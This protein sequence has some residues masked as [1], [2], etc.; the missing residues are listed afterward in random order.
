MHCIECNLTSS[1]YI[2]QFIHFYYIV[3]YILCI[4]YSQYHA[5]P[6]ATYQM[7][8]EATPVPLLGGQSLTPVTQGTG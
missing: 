7:D 2:C 1:I 8:G 5:V 4:L 3:S 6:R